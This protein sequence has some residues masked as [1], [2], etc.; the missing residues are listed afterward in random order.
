MKSSRL[1]LHGCRCSRP[2]SGLSRSSCG[3]SKRTLCGRTVTSLSHTRRSGQYGMTTQGGAPP[4]PQPSQVSTVPVCSRQFW[5]P[6]RILCILVFPQKQLQQRPHV[7]RLAYD[8][9]TTGTSFLRR[10]WRARDARLG[11]RDTEARQD[12]LYW[13]WTPKQC[14][15][16]PAINQSSD[17][18]VT[19]GRRRKPSH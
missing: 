8:A 1:S 5:R 7:S 11:G 18:Q 9:S 12:V 19:G 2:R 3:D 17:V 16:G 4:S 10:L 14:C 13:G 15:R 6:K